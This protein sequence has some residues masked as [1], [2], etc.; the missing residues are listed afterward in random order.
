MVKADTSNT[1]RDKHRHQAK[2]RVRRVAVILSELRVGG[3]ERVVVHLACESKRFGTETF[4]ICLGKEGT[5]AAELR[6][7][8]VPVLALGSEKGYD[9]P[10]IWR[11]AA[12]LRRCR[13]DVINVHDRASL[14]YVYL[15]NR[16]SGTRPIVLSCH[17]L[18]MDAGARAR[19][20]ERFAMRTVTAMTAVSRETADLYA[21][22]L[23]WRGSVRIIPNGVPTIPYAEDARRRTRGD[24]GLAANTPMLLA[25]GNVKPEKGFEDLL[26][27][28]AIL[29][30]RHGLGS[31]TVLVAGGTADEAYRKRLAQTAHAF[32]LG[33]TVRFLGYRDDTA[34]LYQ[35]A[36]AFVLSSHTEG[37]PMVLLE[38]MAAGLPVVATSVGGVPD[39]VT[40][41][42]TGLLVPP[43]NPS[44]LADAMARILDDTALREQMGRA[45]QARVAEQFG[46]GQMAGRYAAVFREVQHSA[47]IRTGPSRPRVLMLGPLPPLTG[48]M[49]TVT[50]NLRKSKL[51]ERCRLTVLNNGKTTPDGRSFLT[52][53]TAQLRL[54]HRILATVRRERTRIVHI[55]TIQFFG[56]WRDCIHMFGARLLGCRVLL[57]S[58]GASFDQWAESMGPLRRALLRAC[59]EVADGV[60]VLTEGWRR[61]LEP[62][63]PRA[64]WHVVPNAVPVP[65]KANDTGVSPPRFLFLGDW[66]PRKG[67]GD[68]VTATAS[69]LERGFSGRVELAGAEKEPGQLD[70]LKRQVVGSPCAPA[71]HILGTLSLAEKEEALARA[72]C[73]VL[74]SYAEGLP[75]AI[76]EAMAHGIPVI[77]TRVGAIHEAVREGVEG[78]LIEPGNPEQLA[79]AM[80]RIAGDLTLR[81]QMGKAAR[82]RIE[83][84]F[85]LRA[86]AKRIRDIYDE[87]LGLRRNVS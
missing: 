37:L 31:F 5:L 86:M 58:H 84:D 68:L 52:G 12:L 69:A 11:L 73:L 63:A 30:D 53:A 76:L 62:F 51:R 41:A 65:P 56:F 8:Q 47:S 36:D 42:Q 24:L 67:V 66:T 70:S 4:V 77:A 20:I 21:K 23:D 81:Q 55:H 49:V 2:N 72:C 74:P 25:V 43:A 27:A 29:R 79:L 44:A 13:P 45:A 7:R 28:A 38:A 32:R 15:A 78:F 10:A 33:E 34:N 87:I 35:A 80:M 1:E 17:G 16:L 85:S 54:L 50:E 60:I 61:R 71:V 59:L 40:D 64:R 26:E 48:G 46:I 57:H 19:W 83:R 6:N 9:L 22:F 14:P 39:A 18:L 75:M 82:R 3:A